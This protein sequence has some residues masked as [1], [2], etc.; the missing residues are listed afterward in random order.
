MLGWSHSRSSK[1]AT[2]WAAVAFSVAARCFLYRACPCSECE[3]S[4]IR[5][6]VASGAAQRNYRTEHAS[7]N[8][9]RGSRGKSVLESPY[10]RLQ[11]KF[12]LT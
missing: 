3:S 9:N 10:P 6:K 2:G 7:L 11:R 4:L 12:D 8:G 1:G 5:P